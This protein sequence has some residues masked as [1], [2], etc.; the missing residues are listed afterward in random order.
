MSN[1][2]MDAY[3][4]LFMS[5]VLANV[6]IRKDEIDSMEIRKHFGVEE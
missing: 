6:K 4:E 1:P 3:R 2:I 5:L